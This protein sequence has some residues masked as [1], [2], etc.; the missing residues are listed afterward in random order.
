MMRNGEW[1]PLAML[2]HDTSVREFGSWPLIGTPIKT[3]RCRSEDFLRPALNPFE[4]CP[5]GSLPH[6]EWVEGL[7]GWP[8]GWTDSRAS[9]TDKF[10]QWSRS[11]GIF[12]HLPQT[13]D[14]R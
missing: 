7:M 8:I 14:S 12:C 3:Q 6:P 4:L 11:H 2:E 13:T 5:K 10:R 9:A 1:Y